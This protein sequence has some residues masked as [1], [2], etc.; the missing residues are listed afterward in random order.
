MITALEDR[1]GV[2]VGEQD[3][4]DEHFGSVARLLHLIEARLG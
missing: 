1:L 2:T 4:T 3:I